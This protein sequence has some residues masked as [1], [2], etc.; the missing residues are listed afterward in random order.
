M[1]SGDAEISLLH[2]PETP[3]LTVPWGNT[4]GV[5]KLMPRVAK[6]ALSATSEKE[7]KLGE[8]G[9]KREGRGGKRRGGE[10]RLRKENKSIYLSIEK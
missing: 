6:P 4:T 7:E 9:K 8:R 3:V 1:I 5:S 10:G 2:C